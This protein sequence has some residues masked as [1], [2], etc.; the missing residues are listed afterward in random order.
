M[1]LAYDANS[2]ISSVTDSA[3]RQV[4]YGYDA[5][6]NLT[7]VTDVRGKQWSY[8]YDSNHLLLSRTD[9]NGHTDVANTYDSVGR[10]AS[11]KDALN[12]TRTWS[13]DQGVT[14]ITSPS[15]NVTKDYYSNGALWKE[16]QGFGTSVTAST[17]Y[18]YDAKTMGVTLTTDPN[19]HT[20]GAT[21][22]TAGNLLTQTD[23][24]RPQDDEHL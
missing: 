5:N 12:R 20:W 1:T 19:G 18:G 9:P 16:T 17:T 11:Q 3:G 6:A 22:D 23:P 7:S 15:G 4:I 14:T 21:Y 10:L 13:F 8:S 2:R 24:P